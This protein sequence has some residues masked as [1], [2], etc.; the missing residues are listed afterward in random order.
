MPRVTVLNTIEREALGSTRF[1][2]R[3]RSDGLT[4]AAS[5][6]KTAT[7]SREGC[8]R[9]PAHRVSDRTLAVRM[10]SSNRVIGRFPKHK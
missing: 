8:D 6:E 1:R 10:R 5:P 4:T 3:G 2:R 9:L 7:H